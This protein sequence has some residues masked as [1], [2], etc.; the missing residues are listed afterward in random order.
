MMLTR[1]QHVLSI[2]SSLHV[3]NGVQQR[4]KQKPELADQLG[5]LNFVNSHISQMAFR[6]KIESEQFFKTYEE[7][8]AFLH[9]RQEADAANGT[10]FRATS[11]E[12]EEDG[13]MFEVLKEEKIE[14]PQC[15]VCEVD[16][17]SV[18]YNSGECEKNLEEK[19]KE[20]KSR[21]FAE[22]AKG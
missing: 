7:A 17:C 10:T 8:E 13:C 21:K 18:I 1:T 3:L 9:D 22:I 5:N 12:A 19:A 16:D 6:V 15:E 11:I 2:F 4:W 14:A 20:P